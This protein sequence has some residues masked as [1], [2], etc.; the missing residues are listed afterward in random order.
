MPPPKILTFRSPPEFRKWLSANHKN[1]D[2]LWL[3][4]FKKNSKT[5]SITY[6]EALDEA[7][8]FGWIDGQKKPHDAESW[9]Q[10]FTP[11]RARSSWS[12]INTR[13][14]E[15]LIDAGRMKPPGQAEI[16]RAKQDG[17]WKSAYDSPSNAVF[18]EDFLTALRKDAKAKAFFDTLNKANTYAIA[19][20]LQTAKKPETRLR[21]MEMILAM[22]SKGE[23]FH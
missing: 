18:P 7:L 20:R 9:I 2:G 15:R 17:R 23:K 4:I 1:P 12:K 6:A 5:K 16:D 19:Y 10:K 14:A 8:C 13:H 3:Q 11:R 22:L 21:R